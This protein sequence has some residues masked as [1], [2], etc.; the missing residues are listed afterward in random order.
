MYITIFQLNKNNDNVFIK[1][2]IYA[3]T[4]NNINNVR[5]REYGKKGLENFT[6]KV[7]KDLIKKQS[8]RD[9]Q[10]K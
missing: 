9:E 4:V 6:D 5:S 1:N 7:A 10:R 2:S 3:N 8:I